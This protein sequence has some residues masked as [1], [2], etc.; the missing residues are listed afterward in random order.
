MSVQIEVG[1]Q[2]RQHHLCP[3]VLK[4]VPDEAHVVQQ[5]PPLRPVLHKTLLTA[6][7]LHCFPQLH[8]PALL[9]PRCL[10]RHSEALRHAQVF[11]QIEICLQRRSCSPPP[12]LFVVPLKFCVSQR[13]LICNPEPFPLV[14]SSR[15]R[16]ISTHR[17]AIGRHVSW[18]HPA[19]AV[20]LNISRQSIHKSYPL[21]LLCA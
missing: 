11:V 7:L 18:G 17:V 6:D 2:R 20:L 9:G 15:F 5:L 21:P 14:G 4:L 3:P 10:L 13:G 8:A 12:V 19:V 1:V 16:C